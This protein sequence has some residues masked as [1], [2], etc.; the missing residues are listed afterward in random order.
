M[1]QVCL[2]LWVSKAHVP[3]INDGMPR[4]PT[5]TSTFLYHK[6]SVKPFIMGYH[7]TKTQTEETPMSAKGRRDLAFV[8]QERKKSYASKLLLWQM[9]DAMSLI[10]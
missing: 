3:I 2:A 7:K 6:G 8:R 9:P 10:F 1:F 5:N 4:S